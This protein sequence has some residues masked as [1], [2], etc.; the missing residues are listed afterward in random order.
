MAP[1]APHARTVHLLVLALWLGAGSLHL[2]LWA[3]LP[4]VLDAP[5]A[6]AQVATAARGVV[7][8]FGAVA[9]PVALVA[10]FAGWAPLRTRLRYR[11]LLALALAG[12]ALYSR[13]EVSPRLEGLA[14]GAA[15]ERAALLDLSFQ[16]ATGEV[17]VAL[18]LFVLALGAT[19]ERPS[20][21]IQL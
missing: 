1:L 15:D 5:G 13:L 16:L 6:V 20:R 9:G 17:A 21:G 8:A 12:S 14:R 10:L 7:D 3:L 18:L 2:A 19:G 4:G 11:A